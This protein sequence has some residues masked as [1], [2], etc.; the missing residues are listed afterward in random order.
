MNECNSAHGHAEQKSN[1][2][3]IPLHPTPPITIQQ[4][5]AVVARN[6][7]PEHHFKMEGRKRRKSH[8][9]MLF[10]CA[11]V[12][13]LIFLQCS[14]TAIVVV[15]PFSSVRIV[16]STVGTRSRQAHAHLF[17]SF[18]SKKEQE[19]VIR[20]SSYFLL[21]FL[22]QVYFLNYA[23]TADLTISRAELVGATRS[24]HT[25]IHVP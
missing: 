13:S 20:R 16:D 6:G 2:R 3:P 12:A 1:G 9:V 11:L 7:S 4:R 19:G 15:K 8:G 17:Q 23:L 5:P 24:T 10:V 18:S 21:S 14:F 22:H 25:Y